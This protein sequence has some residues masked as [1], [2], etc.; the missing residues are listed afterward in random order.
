MEAFKEIIEQRDS[1]EVDNLDHIYLCSGHHSYMGLKFGEYLLSEKINIVSIAAGHWKNFAYFKSFEHFIDEK[2]REFGEFLDIKF[3][4]DDINFTE[5]FVGE[6][7]AIPT[8]DSLEALNLMAKHEGIMLDPIYSAK[9]F[10]GL[11]KHIK[12]G[13]INTQESVLFIHTGGIFN[14]FNYNNEISQSL[15][16]AKA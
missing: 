13:K 6:G 16:S 11:I 3:N 5:D 2:I 10:A 12:N 4:I 9:A 8:S 7:Y 14:V 1:K 15:S